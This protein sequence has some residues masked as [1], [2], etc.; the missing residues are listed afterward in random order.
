[1]KRLLL[2]ALAGAAIGTAAAPAQA[3]IIVCDGV[4]VFV[5]CF[6]WTGSGYV[7]C[8]VWVRPYCISVENV[9]DVIQ[10]N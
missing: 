5:N 7:H 3:T 6:H 8:D 9:L 2:L 10:T 4:P 1:M